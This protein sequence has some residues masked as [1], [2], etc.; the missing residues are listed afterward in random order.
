MTDELKIVGWFNPWHYYHGYEQVAKEHEGEPGKIA[1]CRHDEAMAE[2]DLLRA[3]NETLRQQLS[4]TD[5]NT[6]LLHLA[7]IRQKS[8]VGMKPMLSELAD[9][10]AEK[11]KGERDMAMEDAATIVDAVSHE[12]L[13]GSMWRNQFARVSAAIRALKENENEN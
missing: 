2:I 1:L 7:Y 10:I 5:E 12:G 6:L 4:G 11:I 9:A 3:E 13:H 8:G